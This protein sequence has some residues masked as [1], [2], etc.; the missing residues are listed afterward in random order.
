MAACVGDAQ[1]LTANANG[2]QMAPEPGRYPGVWGGAEE[3]VFL[4]SPRPAVR[5]TDG[6][7]EPSATMRHSRNRNSQPG[8]QFWIGHLPQQRVFFRCPLMQLGIE[9][10]DLQK[11]AAGFHGFV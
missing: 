6:D 9:L 11:N 5:E 10:G 2:G 3:R 8:R 4:R 1:L 7:A